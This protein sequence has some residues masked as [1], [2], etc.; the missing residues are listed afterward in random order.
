LGLAVVSL[1]ILVVLGVVAGLVLARAFGAAVARNEKRP[2]GQEGEEERGRTSPGKDHGKTGGGGRQAR[3][4]IGGAAAVLGIVLGLA[5]AASAF[6]E[7]TLMNAVPATSLGMVLG[8]VGYALGA[9]RLGA[10]AATL[11]V[12][13]LI[14]G[15]A[16]SQGLVPGVEP[17]DHTE[18]STIDQ[19]PSAREHTQVPR[20]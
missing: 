11:S 12:V 18:Q 6:P 4:L 7:A 16:L 1:I 20:T 2:G 17:S 13:G 8:V 15:M 14:F 9:R 5:G 3:L 19:P 10:V